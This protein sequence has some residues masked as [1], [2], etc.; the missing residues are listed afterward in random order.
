MAKERGGML[1][2]TQK[3]IIDTLNVQPTIDSA[4]EIRKRIDFL[5]S[6]C[7]YAKSKGFVLGIS[8][9]Q[10]S[11]L[12][13]KLAQL[14]VSELRNEGY[15]STFVALRLPYGMQQDE[16]D[17]QLSLD[18]IQA[19]EV[20]TFNIQEIVDNFNM[21]YHFSTT[22]SLS[23]FHKG[24]VKARTRMMVH[25]AIAGERNL[26]VIGADHAAE[27]LT[28][29]FTKF[30]DGAADIS[31]LH[32]LTK[33]QGKQLL[34]TLQVPNRILTKVPTADLLDDESQRPDEEELQLSYQEIDEYLEGNVLAVESKQKI[35]M[36][37]TKTQHKR[38]L[39]V[40]PSSC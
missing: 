7:K 30:G 33:R 9:G 26:L 23:D 25:Y 10:D 32:G 1:E 22:T 40:S 21:M 12:A 2:D 17:A 13:G 11:L 24:N 19:D 35:E 8:G 36:L 3:S 5:K 14:A 39:P 37:Y 6:Y 15:L 4:Q 31:P 18:F 38:S 16:Q 29:F 28:G 27:L 34:T 20:I